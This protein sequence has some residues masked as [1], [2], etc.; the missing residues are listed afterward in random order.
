[1]DLTRFPIKFFV[2][3]EV[4]QET[5]LPLLLHHLRFLPLVV[6]SPGPVRGPLC[7]SDI[8]GET[9]GRGKEEDIRVSTR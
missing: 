3:L 5:P 6:L 7:L 8:G 4:S 2:D 9:E 1:M